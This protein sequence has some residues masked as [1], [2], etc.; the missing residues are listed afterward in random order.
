MFF[1]LRALG[2]TPLPIRLSVL[3]ERLGVGF[4]AQTSDVMGEMEAVGSQ[5]RRNTLRH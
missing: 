2:Y 5:V 3:R 1:A 4:V